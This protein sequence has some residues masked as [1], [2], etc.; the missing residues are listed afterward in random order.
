ML[1]NLRVAF[2]YKGSEKTF[3]RFDGLC[4]ETLSCPVHFKARVYFDSRTLPEVKQFGDDEAHAGG[5]IAYGACFSAALQVVAD[6]YMET[7]DHTTLC[8]ANLRSAWRLADIAEQDL[9]D[10]KTVRNWIY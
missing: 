10:A 4:R 7:A 3:F 5:E 9:P 2:T 1:Q 6:R 8:A